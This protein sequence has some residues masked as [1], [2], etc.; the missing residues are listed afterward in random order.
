MRGLVLVSVSVSML[1]AAACHVPNPAYETSD[2]GPADTGSDP[3]D[4][5]VEQSEG[6]AEGSSGE[7][8]CMLHPDGKLAIRVMGPDGARNP[9]CT[10][11]QPLQLPV[12]ANYYPGNDNIVEHCPMET[13]T[14]D[15]MTCMCDDCECPDGAKTIIHLGDDPVFM[16]GG[17]G[18]PGCGHI[19][20]WPRMGPE[21]CEWGGL[22]LYRGMSQL[23]DVIASNSLDVPPIMLTNTL[24]L[25]LDEDEPCPGFD[26]CPGTLPPPGRHVLNVMGEAISVEQSPPL[27]GV[28]GDLVQFAVDNRM[29]SVTTACRPEVSWLAQRWE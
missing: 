22:L 5:A 12:S 27:V 14:C 21:D 9:D 16:D 26:A 25:S 20:L 8:I 7:P 4:T 13:C 15:P 18:L 11:G 17:V 6:A 29:S 1:A 10:T 24:T 28:F 23:P 19:T 2:G 3:S